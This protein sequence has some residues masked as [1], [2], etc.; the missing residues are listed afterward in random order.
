[1][2][3]IR[4]DA[5]ELQSTVLRRWG[6]RYAVLDDEHL[7][8]YAPDTAKPSEKGLL[9]DRLATSDIVGVELSGGDGR[10]ILVIKTARGRNFKVNMHTVD[11]L[12]EW[13]KD[14]ERRC[15]KKEK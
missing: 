1:M 14:I 4:Q 15:L 11:R 3:D 8:F 13:K 12:G 10:H 9:T 6:K 5:V 7:C 2:G